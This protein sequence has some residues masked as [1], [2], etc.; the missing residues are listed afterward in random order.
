MSLGVGFDISKPHTIPSLLSLHHAHGSR[1]E[2]SASAPPNHMYAS[3]LPW[4]TLEL[5][6]PL[7]SHSSP[8]VVFYHSGALK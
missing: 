2:P 8:G 5:R 6:Y 7:S 4:W 3:A 1:C